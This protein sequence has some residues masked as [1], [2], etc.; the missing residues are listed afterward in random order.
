[1]TI[2]QAME[3]TQGMENREVMIFAANVAYPVD[4][5]FALDHPT[6]FN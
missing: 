6:A 4:S 1:M 2:R 5:T 3:A